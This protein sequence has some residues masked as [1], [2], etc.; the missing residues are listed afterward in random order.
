[1]QKV[2]ENSVNYMCKLGV[3][4]YDW[5]KKFVDFEIETRLTDC[6][7]QAKVSLRFN[8]QLNILR[9]LDFHGNYIFIVN[10]SNFS[11]LF[12]DWIFLYFLISI[13]K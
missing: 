7:I 12:L 13:F 4:I 9:I 6:L 11:K 2:V 1:M 5:V 8:S 3:L 10:C